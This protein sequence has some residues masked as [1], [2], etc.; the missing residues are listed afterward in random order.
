MEPELP[1]VVVVRSKNCMVLIYDFAG[2]FGSGFG[3]TLLVDQNIHYRI[4]TW[5]S[6][7]DTNSSN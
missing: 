5:S 1:P 4:G 7:E 2:A 3:S 6:N